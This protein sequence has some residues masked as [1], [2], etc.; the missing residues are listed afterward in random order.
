MS[1]QDPEEIKVLR[2]AGN[3]A[4]IE[5]IRGV[6]E[7]MKRLVK[8]PWVQMEC[9]RLIWNFIFHYPKFKKVFFELG[10]IP[11][12][13]ESISLH[14][15]SKL[16]GRHIC[17]NGLFIVHHIAT[18]ITTKSKKLK[19]TIVHQ[20]HQEIKTLEAMEIIIKSMNFYEKDPRLQEAGCAA[21]GWWCYKATNKERA[22][23]ILAGGLDAVER[24]H[25]NF[26]LQHVHRYSLW[27]AEMLRAADK[28]YRA[29]L[30]AAEEAKRRRAMVDKMVK[31]QIE[32][33]KDKKS[34]FKHKDEGAIVD[35]Y[36]K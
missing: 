21:L 20:M 29:E 31:M 34:K 6:T 33:A 32:A 5:G 18:T 26:D 1:R 7:I 27:T 13:F 17:R 12:L 11:C 19:Q 35:Y 10:G 28:E 4:T 25:A 9:T 23:C 22:K 15:K 30:V 36:A 14:Y 16:Y 3:V 24:A 2:K 8:D